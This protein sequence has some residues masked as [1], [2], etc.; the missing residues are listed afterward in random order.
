MTPSKT[1]TYSRERY[2]RGAPPNQ[3]LRYKHAYEQILQL[4]IANPRITGQEISEVTGYSPATISGI[5]SSQVFKL[6]LR[7]VENSELREFVLPLREKLVEVASLALDRL[8]ERLMAG[9]VSA[10]VAQSIARD[11]LPHA[12]PNKGANNGVN[13]QINLSTEQITSMAREVLLRQGEYTQTF[14]SKGLLDE[15]T[16]KPFTGH[17]ASAPVPQTLTP[18]EDEEDEI[19]EV[20]EKVD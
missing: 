14:P 18:E 11:L 8:H 9:T 16:G 2:A 6:R 5:T 13:V 1:R 15:F 17:T 20:E 4:L 7:E 3:P 10:P 19:E 12:F